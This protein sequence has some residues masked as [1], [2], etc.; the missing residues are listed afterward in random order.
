MSSMVEPRFLRLLLGDNGIT[1]RP[2]RWDVGMVQADALG[3]D[4]TQTL[5][6]LNA[7]EAALQPSSCV[8]RSGFV[9]RL[10]QF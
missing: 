4:R 10:I 9:D 8:K 3:V 5:V 2:C 7:L 1:I 6:A